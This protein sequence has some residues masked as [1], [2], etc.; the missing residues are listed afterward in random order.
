[1]LDVGQGYALWRS[2]DPFSRY[3]DE[4][5]PR[6]FHELQKAADRLV[7]RCKADVK[8]EQWLEYSV[9]GFGTAWESS[10]FGDGAAAVGLAVLGKLDWP[11]DLL[12]GIGQRLA[13]LPAK[14][15]PATSSEIESFLRS[16]RAHRMTAVRTSR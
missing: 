8:D 11:D 13:A 14:Q 15:K 12:A 5:L 1:M 9:A 7:H 4:A 6:H 3:D 2:N 10:R 16:A